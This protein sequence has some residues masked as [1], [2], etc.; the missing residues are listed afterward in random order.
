MTSQSP[1]GNLSGESI[2]EKIKTRQVDHPRVNFAVILY[3]MG[4]VYQLADFCNIPPPWRFPFTAMAIFIFIKH[5][6]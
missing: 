5:I 3:H 1:R 2:Y 4:D 6:L